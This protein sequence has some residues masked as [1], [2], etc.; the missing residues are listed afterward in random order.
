[1]TEIAL[2]EPAP[3]TEG[4][5][6]QIEAVAGHMQ[7]VVGQRLVRG[8]VILDGREFV[9]CQFEDCDVYA[10]LAVCTLVRTGFVECRFHWLPPISAA[11][12]LAGQINEAARTGQP[13]AIGV[14]PNVQGDRSH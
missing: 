12:D 9:D 11:I 10:R 7:R 13:L 4:F 3:G 1:M 5:V 14:W 8:N 2:D 6:D